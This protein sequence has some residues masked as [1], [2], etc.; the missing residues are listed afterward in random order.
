MILKIVKLINQKYKFW[1]RRK[2]VKKYHQKEE[3]I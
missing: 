2:Q 1:K 3:G